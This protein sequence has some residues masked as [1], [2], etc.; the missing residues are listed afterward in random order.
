MALK[1]D[2]LIVRQ[3]KKKRK[4]M[5]KLIKENVIMDQTQNA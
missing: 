4:M 2:V 5:G 1:E 3:Q